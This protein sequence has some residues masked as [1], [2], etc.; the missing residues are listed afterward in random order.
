MNTYNSFA[1]L[2]SANQAQ[3]SESPVSNA[4]T[5]NIAGKQ[6]DKEKI[7]EL[8][9]DTVKDVLQLRGLICMCPD[10]TPEIKFEM[11][12]D[13]L[14]LTQVTLVNPKHATLPKNLLDD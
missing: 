9:F 6:A 2:A 5:K 4:G 8:I 10:F 14:R 11:E 1:E 13:S 3:N 7:T 12:N